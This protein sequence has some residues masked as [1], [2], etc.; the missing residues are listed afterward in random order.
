MDLLHLEI[1]PYQKTSVLHIYN[2][3]I[4]MDKIFSDEELMIEIQNGNKAAFDKLYK[5]H[6]KGLYRYLLRKCNNE[7]D[8]EDLFQEVW[9]K[10]YKARSKFK[11][12]ASF[13]TYLYTIANHHFNDY[14]RKKM[15]RKVIHQVNPGSEE[16]DIVGGGN[17]QP[18]FQVAKAQQRH[19]ML[20]YVATLP[21]EQRD[22]FYLREEG[23]FSIDEIA[24]ILKIKKDTAKSR[25]RYAVKKLRECL[26]P[27]E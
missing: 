20:E 5:R 17:C 13:K 18:E 16:E 23:G 15:R 9:E 25:L 24:K 12:N 21:A 27:D 2:Y 14:Y 3:A 4:E 6:I 1:T 10:M 7:S 8:A 19:M 22:V 26:C 11:A